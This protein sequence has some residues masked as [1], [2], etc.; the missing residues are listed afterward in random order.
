[1]SLNFG[2]E[3][4]ETGTTDLSSV[5]SKIAINTTNIPT[6]KNSLSTQ[7]GFINTNTNNIGKI[8]VRFRNFIAYANNLHP[9]KIQLT[10]TF[11]TFKIGFV[12]RKEESGCISVREYG[13]K[14]F[15]DDCI[16]Y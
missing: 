16:T 10:F 3:E 15:Q 4:Q 8:L 7:K 5:E 9:L 1:M 6:N 12:E 2:Y 11:L 14:H 13:A